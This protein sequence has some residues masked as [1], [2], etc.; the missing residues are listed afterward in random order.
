MQGHCRLQIWIPTVPSLWHWSYLTEDHH[1]C[2]QLPNVWLAFCFLQILFEQ[3]T[4]ANWKATK[5]SC[6]YIRQFRL[7]GSVQFAR[8]STHRARHSQ[9]FLRVYTVFTWKTRAGKEGGQ[10]SLSIFKECSVTALH[11][12]QLCRIQAARQCASVLNVLTKG[13]VQYLGSLS[14]LKVQACM[15]QWDRVKSNYMESAHTVM[16]V[17]RLFKFVFRPICTDSAVRDE[18]IGERAVS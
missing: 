5:T 1:F 9:H 17:R 13:F 7:S 4:V 14:A 11:E 10:F 18:S 16:H 6:E 2:L 8:S 3:E 15:Y 12:K